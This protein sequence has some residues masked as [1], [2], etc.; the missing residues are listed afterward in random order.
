MRGT[1][2]GSGIFQA[3]GEREKRTREAEKR[4]E[5]RRR[6]Q[7]KRRKIFLLRENK[8][9]CFKRMKALHTLNAGCRENEKQRR[10]SLSL[11]LSFSQPGLF[12]FYLL[13]SF[14]FAASLSAWILASLPD[15]TSCLS[16]TNFSIRFRREVSSAPP[17]V[18]QQ[19]FLLVLPAVLM[20]VNVVSLRVF[21]STSLFSYQ[22]V[23]RREKKLRL[24]RMYGRD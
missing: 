14:D 5:R 18:S 17:L 20:E 12:S 9:G 13:L 8:R 4:G 6:R 11:S 22:A 3:A 19:T 16:S 2:S 7:K 24:Q 21:P 10:R 23:K 15:S 1:E